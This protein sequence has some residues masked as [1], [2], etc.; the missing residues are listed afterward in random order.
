VHPKVVPAMKSRIN[1]LK[2][3]LVLVPGTWLIAGV[4]AEQ[5]DEMALFQ[6]RNQHAYNAGFGLPAVA[7]RPVQT[8]E[9]Q[10]ALEHSNQFMGGVSGDEVLLLDGETTE[11]SFRH[12]QRFGP[13]WQMEAFVPFIAHNE[14][15]FDRAID[16]WHQFF[17]LPDADR[18]TAPFFDLTYSY[19]NQ[20]GQRVVV[21]T[22]QSG[23]GDIQL[24][25]QRSLG[26]IATADSTYSETIVR[27]GVKLPTGNA[28]E[29]RGTGAADM[30]MDIQSPVLSNGGRWRAGGALGVLYAGATNRFAL[31]KQLV[32]Y[33]S[34]GAQ[35][36]HSQRWRIIGQFDWHTPFY[37]SA[38]RE[39]GDP[40]IGLTVGIRYLAPDDQT[41]ELSISEDVAIDTTPDIVAR[42]SWT[43][44]PKVGL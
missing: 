43:Y 29:L 1:I 42:L 4:Q 23:L 11:L 25:I 41:L 28:N 30:Y 34:L 35:F 14:G 26:C 19:Q 37:T 40:A 2:T 21:D 15:E 7:A 10:I 36:V 44:R 18:G 5:G 20:D 3:A 32:A 33:G 16:D 8:R 17:G 24:S 22:P 9:W 6:H 12:R 31:Q 39:L 27:M 13:C 38:L